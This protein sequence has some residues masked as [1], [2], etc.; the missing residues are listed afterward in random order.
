MSN[1]VT[2]S[3]FYQFITKNFTQGDFTNDDVVAIFLPLFRTVAAIHHN[4]LVAGLDDI[5]NILVEDE[6]LNIN[7]QGKSIKYNLAAIELLTPQKSKTFEISEIYK[8]TTEV[9]DEVI[10]DINPSAI[11]FDDKATIT[12]PVYLGNY[13]SYEI[14]LGHHDP[15]T[16][17][18]CLGMLMASVALHF[19]FTIEDDLKEFVANR[20]SM[21]FINEKIHPAIANI[22]LGMT[23]LDRKKRW[24]DVSE[25]LE[26]LKNYRDYNPET[27]YDLSE[28]ATE[29]KYSRNQF[30]QERLR[31]RL[32]DNS[33][34]NRLLY[35]KPNIKFL[36]L[37]V[38]SVPH[39]LNYSNIDPDTLFF[40]NEALSKKIMQ[41]S[42]ISL[43]KYL[44]IEDNP[45]IPSGLDKIRLECNKDINEYGFSQLK[46][47]LCNLNW[48]NTKENAYEKIVSPLLL[49][50]VNL[51]K[52][53][54]LKDQ[55][56]LNFTDSE[57]EINPVLANV[58]R[59]LYD[60]RLPE[61][62]QL[63]STSVQDIYTLLKQ[64][65]AD[66][67]S[68]IEL[69]LIDKPRIKL[70]HAQAKMTYAQYLRRNK[71]LEQR[72]SLRSLSYSY[73]PENFQPYGLEMFKNYIKPGASSLEYLI[74]PDIK[75]NTFHFQEPETITRELYTLD[76]G[77]V[78][79]FQWEFD[80]CN[81][82]LGN[83]NYKKMSLVR[84]Y[85][86]IIDTRLEN[87]VF[88]SLFNNLPQKQFKSNDLAVNTF[89][90]T[91]NVV[92]SDPT[93][94]KA[95]QCADNG[96][97]YIIQGPPG[98][99]KSQT[100]ANLVANFVARGKKVLFVCEKRAA[101]DVVFHRLKNQGLDELCCLIH[102]SQADKKE[103]I[104]N[105]KK[106]FN[107]ATAAG[108]NLTSVEKT[109]NELV[110]LIEKEIGNI[111]SFHQF[112]KQALPGE[113]ITIRD[114]Y[115]LLIYNSYKS[116]PATL[117]KLDD[118]SGYHDWQVFVSLFEKC[119]KLNLATNNQGYF[120][121]H[122]FRYLKLTTFENFQTIQSAVEHMQQTE[123]KMETMVEKLEF[124]SLP[125]SIQTFQQINDFLKRGALIY[126]F[127]E[128]HVE[129]LLVDNSS[130]FQALEKDVHDIKLR[131][132]Q[133]Q[134]L[135]SVYP[136]WT[137]RLSLTDAR[138]A[139]EIIAKNENKF[140]KFLNGNYRRI[141]KQVTGVY[142]V[143]SHTIKP[144]LSAVL[145]NLICQYETI[146][147][148]D[149]LNKDAELKYK[150]G[151]L[152]TLKNRLP[153][154]KSNLDTLI[155]PYMQKLSADD[156]KQIVALAN[157]SKE[158]ESALNLFLSDF[159]DSTPA[160]IEQNIEAIV[161]QQQSFTPYSVLFSDLKAVNPS[162]I[163]L[164]RSE[165][166]QP[167]DLQAVLAEK[168]LQLYFAK[169]FN[170]KKFNMEMVFAA[171]MKIKKWYK[172]LLH[173]NAK[174]IIS[175]QNN[176]IKQLVVKSEMSV[177]G[178]SEA[179]KQNRRAITE[180]R[181]ILENEF[182]KSIRFKSIREL[183]TAESGLLIREIKPVWLMSPLSVS[184]TLPLDENYFDVVIFD[185]AS[186]ITLEE[187]LPP[188]Y[189]AKQTI[190]VGDEMQ[191]PPSNFFGSNSANIDDLWEEEEMDETFE[192]FSLD[193][194]SFL[195]QGTR[196]FP[197]IML[198]WH[199]RSK[200][201]ALIGF[202]NASFY[203]NELLTIPD[204][205]FH[206]NTAEEIIVEQ[207]ENATRNT[208]FIYEKPISY[209]Y[210][211]NGVYA[212]R[213]NEMEAAYIALLVKS[214]LLENKGLSI[215]IVAFSMEQQGTI[216]EAIEELCV[217]DKSFEN[218]IEQE[219]KR[220]EDNQFV[221]LFVKNLE[222]VQGD[223]RDIII[224]STCYGYDVNHKMLMN[225]GPINKRGGEKRL[226]VIFSR[227]KKSMCVVSSIK[228]HDIKNEYNEGAN[229]F[230]KYLQYAE[231]MSMG[232]LN[233]A[234]TV[235]NTINNKYA[236][237]LKTA[238]G[239]QIKTIL[240]EA[241]Y[242]V[243]TNI[244]QSKF[245]C[246][247]GVKKAGENEY[248]LGIIIDDTTHYANDDI[249]EQYMLKPDI[250]RQNGW[251]ICQVFT[252][253]WV[254]NKEQVIQYLLGNL[255]GTVKALPEMPVYEQFIPEA[256]EQPVVNAAAVGEEFITYVCK[257]ESG[258]K[259][260]EIYIDDCNIT[261]QF[262]KTGTKGQR[263]V[264]TFAT[265][266]EAASEA[267]KLTNQKTAKGY[268][269]Q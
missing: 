14:N 128:Q 5:N 91:Y 197:S 137:N 172:D 89:T 69:N 63:S 16:D 22:I 223:E 153:V 67:N 256:P 52:K 257:T 220:E 211:K 19:D 35:F 189:R 152:L 31:N 145:E 179:E 157:E 154:I 133:L 194:D 99:G 208:K 265:A 49:A 261:I 201:E 217:A 240:E 50:S 253:D 125:S 116:N 254:D 132:D 218:L 225:F 135:S 18:F 159:K 234:A 103:F 79:P 41:Q 85:N 144:K 114:I 34:R 212:S 39:V 171:I 93:Q 231:L 54:G 262:G 76:E 205:Y 92:A 241:G 206:Q 74:N 123:M 185:E 90:T 237:E 113:A 221:G 192:A 139:Y 30:I 111:N 80:C 7:A 250:L 228:Y 193:A 219:Y 1:S 108:N 82:I 202:S 222:N 51:T 15:L 158:I 59:D 68:G 169:N 255:D 32:F 229:Y 247:L 58:L 61:T 155:F 119:W 98:T 122:P 156:K 178:M 48:Y 269:K 143:T 25:I 184:D 29:K 3:A 198:G 260:W 173:I 131:A 140:F 23:E 26:K 36:N 238:I 9:G 102:D 203:N 28:I 57:I 27:E 164:L 134:E 165:S 190:V 2:N 196:K 109:R 268:I 100:I 249:L 73:S 224:M 81:M 6:K 11:L 72:R 215:G 252:K 107:Q 163:Q 177:A 239:N 200:H 120:N 53:K 216:E 94:N 124:L 46:L 136:H 117:D 37:T 95:V 10:W 187:G 70:I 266:K 191:M 43:N 242:E 243:N 104:L 180:G 20:K 130:M 162:I 170:H 199:Y 129:E 87:A 149:Q 64:Q 150:S 214:L 17:I 38:S 210:I 126:P 47:V 209:H 60:I 161:K 166:L 167:T 235:L 227:A 182:S 244:G 105:L 21:V 75:P 236:N 263:L 160:A 106:T 8:Q 233:E 174:Y 40:W 66:N 42:S 97:S 65:I 78:N 96:E 148:N 62:I 175:K 188:V 168:S 259:F 84:D 204:K 141:K 195:T 226:N 56:L 55:F 13:K 4:D 267:L 147:K 245:K 138:N 33:R 118:K 176:L 45:Y 181:K 88:K 101:L 146:Q 44:R 115:D 248:K 186:Q 127:F 230:R 264:K 251:Q 83:F 110:E 121:L 77:E 24:K 183:A 71:K 142:N 232:L 86:E 246:N 258:S 12:F 151:D 213:S 207:I 112:M